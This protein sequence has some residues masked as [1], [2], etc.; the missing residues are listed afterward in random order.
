MTNFPANCMGLPVE[1]IRGPVACGL[2]V[3]FGMYDFSM[4][5]WVCP[6]PGFIVPRLVWYGKLENEKA[7]IFLVNQYRARSIVIDSRPDATIALRFQQEIKSTGVKCW[8]AQY[9][10]T[11]TGNRRIV[12][13]NKEGIITLDRTLTLD[14]VFFGYVITGQLG[15]PQNFRDLAGGKFVP[16]MAASNREPVVWHG[17][18][19]FAWK[20][21]SADHAFH[22]LGYAMTASEMC[23]LHELQTN[24]IPPMKGIVSGGPSDYMDDEDDDGEGAS[25]RRAG[26]VHSA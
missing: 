25:W 22:S 20:S 10:P 4:L 23:R 3:A 17:V 2:D 1:A 12:A 7:A 21:N 6:K 11:L 5:E 26:V 24:N 19:T 13:D 18:P 16:E 9:S 8:R 15:L 14:A